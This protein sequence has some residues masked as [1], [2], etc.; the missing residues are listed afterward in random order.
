MPT[1]ASFITA[2]LA[3]FIL[4][5]VF[6]GGLWITVRRLPNSP[7]PAMLTLASFWGRS[8]LVVFL[9]VWAAAGHWQNAVV[10]LVGFVMARL[11][12]TWQVGR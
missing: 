4:G 10:C 9:F 6:F 12:F 3:G 7:H 5:I 2:L 8:A 1:P 11:A